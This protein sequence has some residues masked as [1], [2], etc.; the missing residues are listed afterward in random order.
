MSTD[1][2]FEEYNK[3]ATKA[4]LDVGVYRYCYATSVSEAK[5]EAKKVLSVLNGRK[6]DY[7]VVLDM[8]DNSLITCGISDSTRSKMVLA[9]KEIIEDAGYEFAMYANLNWINNY[10]NMDML[11]DVDIWLARWRDYNRG[12]EY[13]GKGNLIMWQYSSDSSFA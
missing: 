1:A 11:D 3:N 6:L 13:T 12:P 5:K 2:R 8:E 4:G 7:P 10:L 9:F